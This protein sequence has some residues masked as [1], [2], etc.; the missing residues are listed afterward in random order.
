MPAP[1]F[2]TFFHFSSVVA[3]KLHRE[4]GAKNPREEKERGV[5]IN[6]AHVEYESEKYHYAHVDC[7]GHADYVKNMIV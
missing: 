6:T 7:P 1:E 3:D 4:R 5:T 2:V